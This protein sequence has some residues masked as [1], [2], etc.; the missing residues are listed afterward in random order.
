[1]VV[2]PYT[3]EA[4]FVVDGLLHNEV[5]KSTIHT[6]DTHG[7]TEAVFGLLDL[8]GFGFSPNIAKMLRQ[9]IYTFKGNPIPT[10]KCT[11]SCLVPFWVKLISTFSF[12]RMTIF[13]WNFI[14][15]YLIIFSRL[16]QQWYFA[17]WLLSHE[18]T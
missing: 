3:R 7:H 1:M 15:I 12:V 5:I 18:F 4:P 8:L 16:P 13:K 10:A 14:C 9:H 6:T 2:D 11:I 17:T